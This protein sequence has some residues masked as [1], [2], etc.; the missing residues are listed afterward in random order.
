MKF[1]HLLGVFRQ[2]PDLQTR[3][4]VIYFL[5]IRKDID[6]PFSIDDD[7]ISV[8]VSFGDD[9]SVVVSF[10]DDLLFVDAFVDF[11]F[12]VD[13]SVTMRSTTVTIWLTTP[14]FRIS[15]SE[16]DTSSEESASTLLVEETSEEISE[17]TSDILN[18]KKRSQNQKEKLQYKKF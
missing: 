5:P 13:S 8:V 16:T 3:R 6:L 10:G 4:Q 14:I 2:G 9:I 1:G 11:S 17:E 7:D 15:G 12:E 18:E